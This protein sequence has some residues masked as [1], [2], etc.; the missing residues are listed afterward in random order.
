MTVR[1][2]V[3]PVGKVP[4]V[5]GQMQ[6]L[7]LPRDNA[8]RRLVMY[9]VINITTG[10]TTAPVAT[11]DTILAAI[12]KIGL[13]IGGNQYKFQYD[14]LKSYY[15]EKIEKGSTPP[16]DGTLPSSLTTTKNLYVQLAHDFAVNRKDDTDIRALLSTEDLTTLDL[17]VTWGDVPDLASTANG[18]VINAASSYC[19]VE[20]KIAYD[21]Q[22]K[23]FNSMSNF[24]DIREG[25]GQMQYS[26][27]YTSYDD[28]VFDTSITPTSALILT[29]LLL[30]RNNSGARAD[31][32]LTQIKVEDTEGAGYK[33]LQ[34]DYT[35]FH[36][37]V[38]S[39]YGLE[40][41]DTGVI[42][43]DWVD[44]QGTGLPNFN[45]KGTLKWR[46]LA[47]APASGNDTVEVFTRYSLGKPAK[48]K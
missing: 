24:T 45:P 26:Q 1:R 44:E 4:F 5:A 46:L 9:F 40:T 48:K 8:I 36:N 39:E 38:K 27:A 13:N 10:G 32:R 18:M 47:N 34:R 22:D 14:A 6:K 43:I 15:V 16:L 21:D 37:S 19:K 29:H 42:Y 20:M 7:A 31:D 23:N 35:I 30:S 11:T 2:K 17:E 25:I 33:Y 12:K 28:N 3:I 41:L